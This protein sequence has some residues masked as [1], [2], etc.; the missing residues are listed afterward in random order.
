MIS[1][2]NIPK[3][4]TSKREYPGKLCKKTGCGKIFIPNDSRQKYCCIQ[5][6]IDHNND[7]N[8]KRNMDL[9]QLGKMLKH[10]EQVLEKIYESLKRSN[11]ESFNV[12]LLD[13]EKFNTDTF[14][15]IEKNP[16]TKRPVYWSGNFGIEGIDP[17][18]DTFIVHKKK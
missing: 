5:H 18:S 9:L 7:M 8:K 6:R 3:K 14:R 12:A 15:R 4:R 10:N 16:E 1:K 2:R 17:K 13:H 11:T